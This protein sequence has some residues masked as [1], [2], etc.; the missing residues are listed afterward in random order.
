MKTLI[1]IVALVMSL[2]GNMTHG[3]HQSHL[4]KKAAY[5][6]ELESMTPSQKKVLIQSFYGGKKYNL[7]YTLAAVAWKESDLGANK[8]NMNDGRHSKHPGS[9][10]AYQQR[11]SYLM[12]DPKIKGKYTPSQVTNRLLRDN[13]F[14]MNIAVE[15]LTMWEAHW[16]GKKVANTYRN[17]VASYNCGGRGAKSG[18]GNCYAS[19]I[20]L[21]T[22]VIKMYL[23]KNNIPDTTTRQPQQ[24]EIKLS[25][26]DKP[27]SNIIS[28]NINILKTYH[29]QDT[30]IASIQNTQINYV[31]K[32]MTT[33]EDYDAFNVLDSTRV[34]TKYTGVG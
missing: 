25:N 11:L 12:V 10:G 9:F 21:R 33:K 14:A 2:F 28:A 1:L 34:V 31:N 20:I 32:L 15:H 23:A 27:V 16:K 4:S 7:A 29:K 5:M 24:I 22:K 17:M 3:K 19:D 8:I 18:K 6:K 26:N 30:V 13:K